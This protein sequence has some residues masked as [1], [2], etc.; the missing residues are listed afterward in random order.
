MSPNEEVIK[1]E[2]NFLKIINILSRDKIYC[3]NIFSCC[4]TCRGP[5]H[6]EGS[7]IRAKTATLGGSRSRSRSRSKSQSS[8]SSSRSRSRRCAEGW[9]SPARPVWSVT[10]RPRRLQCSND[11]ATQTPATITFTL[12]YIYSCMK[13]KY[14]NYAIDF[15]QRQSP[16][17][18]NMWT[19]RI[20][21]YKTQFTNT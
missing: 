4:I 21:S 12:K 15:K 6:C 19:N 13:T 7:F 9:S 8:R 18:K 20:L 16:D 1:V 17:Q 10:P 11:P 2:K 14:W 3:I 5:G